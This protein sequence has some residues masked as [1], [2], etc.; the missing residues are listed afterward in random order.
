LIC[1]RN[2]KIATV[3]AAVICST[4]AIA[5]PPDITIEPV[6][7][8]I[9]PAYGNPSNPV[10]W[11]NKLFF[12]ARDGFACS[13][14]PP[15]E[16]IGDELGEYG[17][18]VFTAS[19][20]TGPIL[21]ANVNKNTSGN[22]D[23]LG[24]AS[25]HERAAG[26]T[27]ALIF[28]ARDKVGSSNSTGHEP[29]RTEGTPE[30]TVVVANIWTGA[31]NSN[32]E[33]FTTVMD[34][35]RVAMSVEHGL[36]G[37]EPWITDGT[38]GGT[39]PVG[40]IAVDDYD[41]FPHSFTPLSPTH[42]VFVADD[43]D[44]LGFE[45]YVSDGSTSTLVANIDPGSGNDSDVR[46]LTSFKGQSK[47]VFYASDGTSGREPWVS[48]GTPG[49][50]FRL[51]DIN[52]GPDDS[53]T[54][55]DGDNNGFVQVGSLM[56]FRADNGSTG[57]QLWATDG[58][59]AGTRL[60]K[61]IV[62]GAGGGYSAQAAAFQNLLYFAA[63]GIGLWTSDGTES[64][65]QLLVEGIFPTALR[66]LTVVGKYLY[67]SSGS[68]L[69]VSDGTAEGTAK[70]GQFD[71]ARGPQGLVAVNSQL[72]AFWA[73]NDAVGREIFLAYDS[74]VAPD[75]TGPIVLPITPPIAPLGTFED[76]FF[77]ATA[78]EEDTGGSNIL[79]IE[80]QV[81]GGDWFD[82]EPFDDG[83]DS[84]V[85]TGIDSV[86]FATIGIHELCARGTDEHLNV[87]A[88]TCVD[89]P[90][91]SN[92]TTPPL[93]PQVSVSPNPVMTGETA[94][95][96][97]TAS[98]V[99]T[100]DRDIILIEYQVD[101]GNWTS[102]LTS[103]DG[104]YDEVTESA[105]AQLN[106]DTGGT[107]N[108][109][110]RAT[111]DGFN[112]GAAA[113]TDLQVNAPEAT[114]RLRAI[115]VNQAIQNWRNEV[116]L[117]QSKGT[118]VR[119]FFEKPDASGPN[120]ANGK[121]HGTVG[122]IPLPGSPL[123]TGTRAAVAEDAALIDDPAT[124]D[125]NES[126]RAGLGNSL[127]YTLPQNWIN[128]GQSIELQF[129]LTSPTNEVLGC[130]EPDASADCAVTVVF[131]TAKKQPAYFYSV[132]YTRGSEFQID[133]TGTTGGTWRLRSGNNNSPV[134]TP[135]ATT[136]Q[137]RLS[138]AQVLDIKE[139]RV[140]V[141]SF[142]NGF[143][144]RT[145]DGND[146]D[147]TAEDIDLVGGTVT[148][149]ES[150]VGGSDWAPSIG[151][152]SQVR[153]QINRVMDNMPS[154]GPDF[155]MRELNGFKRTPECLRVNQRLNKARFLGVGAPANIM[156]YGLMRGFAKN[157]KG[158]G[159]AGSHNA[160]SFMWNKAGPGQ[161]NNARNTVA[162]EVAH[163]LSRPHAVIGKEGAGPF[164][165]EGICGATAILTTANFPHVEEIPG[166]E[167]TESVKDDP[168]FTWPTI[169]PLSEGADK[170]IWGF[171]PRAFLNGFTNL[172]IIDPR[173]S[174][175]LM[176][177]CN[178]PGVNQDRWISSYNYEKLANKLNVST[179]ALTQ[180]L[181]V[182]QQFVLVMG[183]QDDDSGDF[184]L[185]PLVYASMEAPDYESGNLNISL[186]DAGGAEIA[187]GKA[188][189]RDNNGIIPS[190]DGPG[191]E[192]PSF[193]TAIALPA[194]SNPIDQVVLTL[195]G[196]EIG[197]TR[198]SSNAPV[199][200]SLTVDASESANG[201]LDV[202]WIA[203]DADN[204]VLDA[205][206]LLS[207]DNGESWQVFATGLLADSYNAPTATLPAGNL[208][209]V[210]LVISDGFHQVE[211]ESAPFLFDAG[212]PMAAI[213]Q[214]ANMLGFS[215]DETIRFQGEGWDPEDGLL[216]G[217]SIS[218]SILTD[219][220]FV[221]EPVP[222][223]LGTGE[224]LEISASQLSPGCQ[225]ITLTAV[226]SDGKEGTDTV[227][228]DVGQTGCD[229]TI[230]TDGFE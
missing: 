176:S 105:Q 84:T 137:V 203:T 86:R 149:S 147:L 135:N 148:L 61:V 29:W 179:T 68:E 13:G 53:N 38:Q 22:C 24:A 138:V 49:G 197:R 151:P 121:L 208:A 98:D 162:H 34:G 91:A 78:H 41:S 195:D 17:Q 127:N 115:E 185:A 118:V 27:D 2:S 159:L 153:E 193:T 157:G 129:E 174:T 198:A 45:L 210:R 64:G 213:E 42:F 26:L 224:V 39:K 85:E 7:V 123:I 155:A 222:L 205:S 70:V 209:V 99:G 33:K 211:T 51:A 187:S 59:K 48:D 128:Q 132:P 93:P 65:T 74:S 202:S 6:D 67:F 94:T 40:N 156:F 228:V 190:G 134:L 177:Y 143:R 120:F 23:G 15:G 79:N 77:T 181:A 89:V 97:I 140:G 100:G 87:G 221:P 172:A 56:Y 214:P 62:A 188:A 50:T 19:I 113:C 103:S 139:N 194:G 212:Y 133:L 112:T 63:A 66:E 36:W 217:T 230:F 207:V 146:E 114:L 145:M 102:I 206:L 204:D 150:V 196:L 122:G 95:F 101:G 109:C 117:I 164:Q 215:V 219:N 69:W 30:T 16:I 165:K 28:R 184:V 9:G 173:Q 166:V 35:T 169:G 227:Q 158:R 175:A 160:S 183:H 37:R 104:A 163:I 81:D 226:D 182:P 106:F 20:G 96:S 10:V 136:E 189:L 125:T 152:G 73:Q 52:S 154:T 31:G 57:Y 5:A 72:L 200:N 170:E 90:V 3:V 229:E 216:T 71:P 130:E 131:R 60:V 8:N 58:T 12:V 107:R 199:I 142:T 116:P 88:P 191:Q 43:D 82:L 4:L 21:V 180:S 178:A 186:L 111:D 225:E 18:E 167:N 124:D 44:S 75:T 119:V 161:G 223:V 218:W 220:P 54:D 11:N 110:A 141:D 171:S 201:Q 25:F 192:S 32:P 108:L 46:L 168:D 76:W 92:D 14:T 80:F 55:D 47:V 1:K 83:Y 126:W 144:V